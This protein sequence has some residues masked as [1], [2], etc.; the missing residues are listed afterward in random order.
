ML[1]RGVFSTSAAVTYVCA[2]T[3]AVASR[4]DVPDD[5]QICSTAYDQTQALRRAGHL[6]MASEQAETCMRDV[7]ASFIRTDCASWFNEIAASQP[8][9]VLEVRDAQGKETN[10]VSV[11]LDGQPWVTGLDGRAKPIDPG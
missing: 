5:K 7:C 3:V 9:I 8:T 4:A 2:T 6:R 10:A 1:G 11:S